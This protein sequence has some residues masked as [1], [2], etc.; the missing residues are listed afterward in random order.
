MQVLPDSLK[1]GIQI[2][3]TLF[4]AFPTDDRKAICC[5]D[6]AAGQEKHV[7]ISAEFSLY[8]DWLSNTQ[9]GLEARNQQEFQQV[10]IGDF[11]RL[12]SC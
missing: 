1:Q 4:T 9:R 8:G 5:V 3:K 12:S 7:L 2:M 6:P 10:I 11:G